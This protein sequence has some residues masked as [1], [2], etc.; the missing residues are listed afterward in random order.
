MLPI[1]SVDV[2]WVPLILDVQGLASL[3]LTFH[4]ACQTNTV[5][6]L[7]CWN[8]NTVCSW[9]CASFW[10][11]PPNQL[12]RLR[13]ITL[14]ESWNWTWRPTRHH[15]EPPPCLS[16]E[17]T[18]VLRYWGRRLKSLRFPKNSKHIPAALVHWSACSQVFHKN[19]DINTKFPDKIYCSSLWSKLINAP[20]CLKE[21]TQK[22]LIKFS[23][24]MWNKK[25]LLG[26]VSCWY[27]H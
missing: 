27:Y 8:L 6:R 15:Q 18:Y 23:Q 10:F 9:K 16:N 7:I 13:Q 25:V 1:P 5:A 2:C 22:I 17:K 21:I 11:Q 24:E 26:F 3:M 14:R 12:S 19:I 4:G 20:P